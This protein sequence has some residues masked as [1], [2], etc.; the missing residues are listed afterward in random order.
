MSDTTVYQ[1]ESVQY[2]EV[3]LLLSFELADKIYYGELTIDD[4][5]QAVR[6]ICNDLTVNPSVG[7]TFILTNME[8]FEKVVPARQRAE[9]FRA[10]LDNPGIAAV[11]GNT[12][13]FNSI[14]DEHQAQLAVDITL[15]QPMPDCKWISTVAR[16]TSDEAAFACIQA[17]LYT[18][19]FSLEQSRPFV[20]DFLRNGAGKVLV[21]TGYLTAVEEPTYIMTDSNPIW[22]V[23]PQGKFGEIIEQCLRR[24]PWLLFQSGKF[25][26]PSL[27][28]KLTA[29]R[30]Q[31]GV[32]LGNP[33]RTSNLQR[34][35]DF[36]VV[37]GI[38]ARVAQLLTSLED[39]PV[40]TLLQLPLEAQQRL[41]ERGLPGSLEF[42]VRATLWYHE[43][44]TKLQRQERLALF[45]DNFGR[46]KGISGNELLEMYRKLI[47]D[48]YFYP[49]EKELV[50]AAARINK[51]LLRQL[52]SHGYLIGRVVH[53]HSERHGLQ[54]VLHSPVAEKDTSDQRVRVN[55]RKVT[56]VQSNTQTDVFKPGALVYVDLNTDRWAAK[57]VETGETIIFGKFQLLESW[58][59]APEVSI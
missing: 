39:L 44:D 7:L 34:M 20:E 53:K 48:L 19:R 41:A 40:E 17:Q 59:P 6:M 55:R 51:R 12:R 31:W 15:R 8:S 14:P 49:N 21:Q 36:E 9:F 56:I 4:L 35:L 46:L 27:T 37:D 58:V 57:R 25:D 13:L 24:V 43:C 26:E 50:E 23:V 47:G 28:A 38:A 33:Y 52:F 42:L 30:P 5:H 29:I 32:E 10:H 1:T 45:K 54:S 3:R 16:A 11:L 2:S 22:S 18:K